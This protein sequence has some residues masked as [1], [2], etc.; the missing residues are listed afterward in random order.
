[1]RPAF[2]NNPELAEATAFRNGSLQGAYLIL[3]AR[4]ARARLPGRC[5]ASTTRRSTPSSSPTGA[6]K[7]NFLCNLGYG[8]HTK[9]HPRNPRPPFEEACRIL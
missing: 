5:P 2:A 7:S 6:W 8:D 4:G 1:M 3:A 9:V